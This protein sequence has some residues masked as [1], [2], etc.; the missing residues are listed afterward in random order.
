MSFQRLVREIAQVHNPYLRFQ[1]GV[2]LALQESAEAYLV[3]LLEDSNLCAIQAKRGL[4]CQRTCSWH[5][6]SKEREPKN[7]ISPTNLKIWSFSG[8]PKPPKVK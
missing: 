5:D 3:G 2:I 6:E 1:S 7:T 4:L 8:P